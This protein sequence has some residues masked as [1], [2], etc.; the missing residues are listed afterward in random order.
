MDEEWN[1]FLE[2]I[3]VQEKPPKLKWWSGWFHDREFSKW[4]MGA[5]AYRAYEEYAKRTQKTFTQDILILVVAGGLSL[6]LVHFLP[7]YSRIAPIIC[8]IPASRMIYR[9]WFD[10]SHDEEIKKWL[11]A[12]LGPNWRNNMLGIIGAGKYVSDKEK[13][14]KQN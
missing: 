1:N 3:G 5:D 9:L 12:E 6:I 8:L 7:Q 10:K 2:S 4:A 13:H 14:E 11:E